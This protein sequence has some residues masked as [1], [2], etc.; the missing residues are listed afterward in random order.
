MFSRTK[1]KKWLFALFNWS[2]FLIIKLVHEYW[3][4][5]FTNLGMY[6]KNPF[7]RVPLLCT[8]NIIIG[9]KIAHKSCWF[10]CMLQSKVHS[11]YLQINSISLSFYLSVSLFLVFFQSL[12]PLPSIIFSLFRY[13]LTF[14]RALVLSL[15]HSL[16]PTLFIF[17]TGLT[18]SNNQDFE[19]NNF[20]QWKIYA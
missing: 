13:T 1:L 19:P 14:S 10:E 11:S 17:F 7:K 18:R 3:K 16:W 9:F 2:L 12:T 15:Y 4:G 20:Y 6:L 8:S 5:S